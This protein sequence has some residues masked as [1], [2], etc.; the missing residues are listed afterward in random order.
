MQGGS[1]RGGWQRGPERER[2]APWR[3]AVLA[4]LAATHIV[5]VLFLGRSV[6]KRPDAVPAVAVERIQ[7]VELTVPAGPPPNVRPPPRLASGAEAP[8]RQGRSEAPRPTAA[9]AGRLVAG[10]S[11]T[12]TGR[13]Q[14]PAG[15]SPR[16]GSEASFAAPPGKGPALRGRVRAGLPGSSDAIVEGFHVRAPPS[17]EDRVLRVSALLFGAGRPETC[18]DVRQRLLGAGPGLARDMDVERLKRLCAD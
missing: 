12:A 11:T 10:R 13:E 3:I 2:L 7:W 6:P 4:A 16:A 14:P 5:I 17:I 8:D 15:L 1:W 9:P 18:A